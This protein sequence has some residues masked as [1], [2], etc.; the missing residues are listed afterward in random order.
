M[1]S[2]D[3]YL[4]ISKHLLKRRGL[5]NKTIIRAP[6]DF[7]V[8]AETLAEIERVYDDLLTHS[9]NFIPEGAIA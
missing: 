7:V 2:I 6:L 9:D 8:D 5:I 4:G 3:C 1:S